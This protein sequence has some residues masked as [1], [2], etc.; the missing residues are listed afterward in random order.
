[1]V[2]GAIISPPTNYVKT[3]GDTMTGQLRML[4]TGAGKGVLL[5]SA[6]GKQTFLG[7][8]SSKDHVL[9]IGNEARTVYGEVFVNKIVPYPGVLDVHAKP[10]GGL[11]LDGAQLNI[12]NTTWTKVLLNTVKSG[13]VDGVE[14]TGASK[15]T[16]SIAGMYL[17][18]GLVF[19]TTV[20]DNKQYSVAIRVDNIEKHSVALVG[21]SG[22]SLSIPIV[23]MVPLTNTH[24]VELWVY[25]NDGSSN[26]DITGSAVLVFLEVHRLRV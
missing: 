26:P 12:V 25:H 15:I 23:C 14:D 1:M 4:G 18:H 21:G 9:I 17:I 5:E 3:A 22:Q 7:P 10:S 8:S 20:A 6:G 11:Y 13:F 16:P 2:M 24:Y 19:W